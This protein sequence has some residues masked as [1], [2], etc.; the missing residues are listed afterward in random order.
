MAPRAPNGFGH[1]AIFFDVILPHFQDPSNGQRLV[2]TVLGSASEQWINCECFQ[3]IRR[4]RPNCAVRPECKKRDIVFFRKY[5][6]DKPVSV[7]ETKVLYANYS[8]QK[9]IALVA[10]LEAQMR[11]AMDWIGGTT[12]RNAVGGLLVS[13]DWSWK[14]QHSGETGAPA[15]HGWALNVDRIEGGLEN[16]FGHIHGA[17]II[18]GRVVQAGREFDVTVRF[19]MLRLRDPT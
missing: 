3:A 12:H 18:S 15:N 16:E 10:R 8:K 7:I 14:D 6:V 1:K 5:G 9:Q 2:D 11:E 4:A 19:E 13:F 17:R